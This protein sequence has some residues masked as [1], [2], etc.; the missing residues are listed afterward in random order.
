MIPQTF[1]D[2]H[3]TPRIE[4]IPRLPFSLDGGGRDLLAD[5]LKERP[6]GTMIEIGSF[7]CGSAEQWLDASDTLEVVG[8]DPW[9]GNWASILTRYRDNPVFESC[10]KGIEDRDA[11]I[12]SLALHGPFKSAMA[13]IQRHRERFFPFVGK[14]PDALRALHAAGVEA[15]IIYF[16]SDKVLGDLEVGLELYPN[17]ILSGDDW[18]WGADQGYPVQTAVK[19]FCRRHGFEVEDRRA[20]WLIHKS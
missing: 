8:V 12:A 7:L 1:K 6:I 11:A 16:D 18:R 13:N 4:G 3:P 19:E 2:A 17:A 10:W 14:S 15:D 20:T 9:E 5:L